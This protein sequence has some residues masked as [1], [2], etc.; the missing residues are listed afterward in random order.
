MSRK[1]TTLSTYQEAK[2]EVR[3]ETFY[4]SGTSGERDSALLQVVTGTI[5]TPTYRFQFA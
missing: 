4:R 5:G 2:D 3:M 1:A